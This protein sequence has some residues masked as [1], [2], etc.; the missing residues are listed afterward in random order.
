MGRFKKF[1]LF[2]F[3]V[4]I[5]VPV[6]FTFPGIINIKI[7]YLF[8]VPIFLIFL[9][10]VLI[11]GK[12][13]LKIFDDK[14]VILLLGLIVYSLILLPFI[15]Y[16]FRTPIE[17]VQLFQL[18]IFAFI[19][20]GDN[21]VKLSKKDIEKTIKLLFYVS[22]IGAINALVYFIITGNR[23]CGIW[24]KW[25]IF[26]SLAFGFFYSLYYLMFSEKKWR[27]LIL[28]FLFTA[29]I[30]VGRTRGSW[31]IVPLSIIIV[32]FFYFGKLKKKAFRRL[33]LF[34]FLCI[35][36]IT[37]LGLTRQIPSSITE[38]FESIFAGTQNLYERPYRWLMSIKMFTGHPF[39][40]GLGNHRYYALEYA[41][42]GLERDVEVIKRTQGETVTG[43]R[44]SPHSDWFRLLAEV[45]LIG[46]I[47]Y[48]LFWAR[49]L[50]K[51]LLKKF[52]NI[53]SI[54]MA[55]F[56]VSIFLSTFGSELITSA[57]SI[58]ILSYYLFLRTK[59][60]EYEK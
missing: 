27:Y 34:I 38:R 41:V 53:P 29:T 9:F 55:T 54:I 22:L 28:L 26:G 43:P 3:A 14:I 48:F 18:V 6:Q 8:F 5:F 60:F 16:K 20:T 25:Y 33:V 58:I 13:N 52:P 10:E 21:F 17:A 49:I 42:P 11:K 35:S 32:L 39:G 15:E 45:G 46:F 4:S 36:L 44:L 56:L 12:R 24:S 51:T 47:L 2:A 23:F 40:V 31:I 57:G 30:I 37:I 50:K 1:L 7:Q 59:N 19:L